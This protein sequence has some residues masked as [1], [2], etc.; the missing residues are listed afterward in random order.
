MKI[1]IN[2][3]DYTAVLDAVR[4]LT[5][6]RKL[7]QPSSCRLWMSL[8]TSGSLATPLRNQS[9]AV[10]GDDGTCYFTGYIALT[11]LPEYAGLA[12]EGPRYRIAIQALSDE[13]LL[14]QLLMPLSAGISGESAGALMTNLVTRMGLTS[15]STQGVSLGAI[16]S[17]FVPDRSASWSKNA[18]EVANMARAAYRAVN[19]ALSISPVQNVVHPLNETDGSLNLAALSFT[20][21]AKR[22]L[23]NDVTV[24]GEHEPV[25]YVTEYFVGDG[26]TTQFYLAAN[27]FFPASSTSTIIS[28]L[29]NE[30]QIDGRVWGQTGGPGA[31]ALGPGGLVMN[32]GNGVDGQTLLAWN[33]PVEMVG[34][35]L[36]EAVGVSLAPGSTGILAGFFVGTDTQAD[37]I[38]GFQ[39]TAQQGTGAVTLQPLIQGSPAGTAYAIN[40]AN[41]Y[42]LRIR[43]HCAEA[44]RELAV[45]RSFGDSGPLTYGGAWNAAS[46]KLQIEIQQFVNGVGG[47][48][49]TLYDGAIASLPG[50]CNVVAASSIN[51]VGTMRALHLTNLGSGWVVSTPPSGGPF[52]R[53][54]G[55]TGEAAQ[56]H[57]ERTGKVVFYTGYTPAVGEQVAVSYRTIGRAVGRAVNTASQQ[58]LAQAGMPAEAAWIGSV[59]SPPAR[60]SADCR[61]AALAIEMAAAGVSALWSGTYKGGRLSLASDVWPG[62]ALALNAPS[63]DLNAQVVVREVTV[64]YKA[65]CPDLVEYAIAFANDWA[66]DLAIKTGGMVPADAWLPAPIAPTVLANLTGLTVTALNGSTVTINA[67]VTPPTGGGFEIRT[68][69]FAF[70]PGED[71]TLVMRSTQPAMTFSRITANDR[72]YIRMYDGSTPPNYS[73][74]STALFINLP[75]GS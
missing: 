2:G 55:T 21:N 54:L 68:R 35:L 65:S 52:T 56:C 32:G 3:Q 8:A 62:D 42:T 9:L 69:D 74:F 22:A 72:F 38:A 28:E 40:S 30:P 47:M 75:L 33:D 64:S 60:S 49:V 20:A 37:C 70:M 36:L 41:Q 71:P 19:G 73:E 10:T 44:E 66:D 29:F 63:A 51:L 45:Y 15:L 6:E 58:A 1:T 25:A 12:I 7:N 5:I 48:P 43:I 39:A 23:A 17:H 31:L 18:G 53:T 24:C 13:I 46:G 27:P 57:L 14:D 34:T 4:P 50:I 16:V 59:T 61:N 26:V 67:G 11:P